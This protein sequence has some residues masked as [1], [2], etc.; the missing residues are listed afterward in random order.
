MIHHR[1]G[2]V[3]LAMQN[4]FVSALLEEGARQ[5]FH[6]LRQCIFHELW[7][8]ILRIQFIGKR[9]TQLPESFKTGPVKIRL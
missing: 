6:V 1:R 3:H 5:G 4:L 2:G 9:N 8:R 7:Q